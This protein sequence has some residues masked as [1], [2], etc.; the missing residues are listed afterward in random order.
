LDKNYNI[1]NLSGLGVYAAEVK[2]EMQSDRRS[3]EEK[4]KQK[5]LNSWK[6]MLRLERKAYE[7]FAN[8][9]KNDK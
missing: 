3:Q 5:I 8:E 9:L 2:A 6:N 4:T 7:N 1:N